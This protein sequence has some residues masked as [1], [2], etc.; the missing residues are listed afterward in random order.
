MTLL[1]AVLHYFLANYS[2]IIQWLLFLTGLVLVI[3]PMYH[4]FMNQTSS[5]LKASEMCKQRL[6]MHRFINLY[7]YNEKP[8]TIAK[9]SLSIPKTTPT[10]NT[11][12]CL[13]S[14]GDDVAGPS[15]VP[16]LVNTGNSCFLNSVLQVIYIYKYIFSIN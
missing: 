14:N 3:L 7:Y 16:G 11:K 5:F 1:V 12:I 2:S 8:E 13:L 6:G 4:G 9:P 10:V 15:L